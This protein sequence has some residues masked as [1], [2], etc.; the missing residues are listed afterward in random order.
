MRI[1]K[2]CFYFCPVLP[3]LVSE[4]APEV[5]RPELPEPRIATVEHVGARAGAVGQQQRGAEAQEV[6]VETWK[7]NKT[8]I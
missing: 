1:N 3:Y 5:V 7:K 8:I 4:S 2:S 6:L